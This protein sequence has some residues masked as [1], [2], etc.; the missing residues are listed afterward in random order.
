MMSNNIS[1]MD[2]KRINRYSQ[3]LNGEYAEFSNDNDTIMIYSYEYRGEYAVGFVILYKNGI[4]VSRTSDKNI[5][6]IWW[7]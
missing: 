4:E 7:D 1:N 6:T 5:D 3:I 2:G